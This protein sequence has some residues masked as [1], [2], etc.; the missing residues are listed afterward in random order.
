M[1]Q[2]LT[3]PKGEMD[4]FT[5]IVRNFKISVS[6]PQNSR[7]EINKDIKDLNSIISQLNP[8]DVYRTFHP[9]TAHKMFFF[10]CIG[11]FH[12]DRP[13]SRPKQTLTNWKKLKEY[14]VCYLTIIKLN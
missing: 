5:I 4:E 9:T 7:H 3:Q 14:K 11:E 13:Y 1:R 10:K 6:N 8:I 2:K 12:Q